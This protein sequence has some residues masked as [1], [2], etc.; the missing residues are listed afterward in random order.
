MKNTLL[1]AALATGLL[2]LSVSESQAQYGASGTSS[3]SSG[4]FGSRTQG[5]GISS[6]SG[7]GTSSGGTGGLGD[8]GA[9]QGDERYVRGNR[10]AGS[11]VGSDSADTAP[12]GVSQSSGGRGAAGGGIQSLFGGS[13]GFADFA[14]Q[15]GFNPNQGGGNQSRTQL[16][17]PIRLGFTPE[18]TNMAGF[19]TKFETRLTRI[20]A[21]KR[22][23]P[24]DVEMLGNTAI[25]R[26]VVASAEDRQ[27]A[28]DLA[29][30][31]PEVAD[32]DN[33]LIVGPVESK[34]EE[35]PVPAPSDDPLL[36]N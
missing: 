13:G 16:R 17:I 25:L 2:A 32:V 36:K 22:L 3:S 12:V 29:M 28:E 15:N 5:S 21:L 4:L 6:R 8:A 27:L 18:P 24:I 31:E 34:G 11:F 26:G 10:D 23:G 30:M 1:I 19:Q 33:E 20:P 35:L 9:V 7:G 14:R